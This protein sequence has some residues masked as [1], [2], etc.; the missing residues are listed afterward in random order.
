MKAAVMVMWCEQGQPWRKATVL[1][2][3]ARMKL[4]E[5]LD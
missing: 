4:G 5:S 3:H 2:N 1:L